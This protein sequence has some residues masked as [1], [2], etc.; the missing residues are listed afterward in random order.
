MTNFYAIGPIFSLVN[1]W[2]FQINQPILSQ[3]LRARLAAEN[4]RR[5]GTYHCMTGLQF[6]KFWFNTFI[7]KPLFGQIQSCETGDQPNSDPSPYGFHIQTHLNSSMYPEL[8]LMP[9]CVCVVRIN[10]HIF[11][12]LRATITNLVA[13]TFTTIILFIRATWVDLFLFL[14]LNTAF[15]ITPLCNFAIHCLRGPEPIKKLFWRKFTIL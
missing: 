7:L 13:Y 10:F 9:Q 5:W 14:F 2:I 8:Y 15:V 11:R 3:S 4:I 6:N 12:T 1:D